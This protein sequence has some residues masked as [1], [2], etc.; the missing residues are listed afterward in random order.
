MNS[1]EGILSLKNCDIGY[2]L[3]KHQSVLLENISLNLNSSNLIALIGLNGSGK[4]SLLK[5][6]VNLL[7]GLKGQID[8]LG[9]NILDYSNQELAKI[10]GF[11]S[12]NWQPE[13]NMTVAELVRLGR[14]PYT[15]IFGQ[16]NEKDLRH[17]E[18]SILKLGLDELRNRPLSQISD[19]ER[20]RAML[21][22]VFAQQT[23]IIVLDEPTAF[24][25]IQHKY[26]IINSLKILCKDGITVI[27]STHDINLASFFVD[28]FWLIQ[29]EKIMNGA[30]EDLFLNGSIAKL[31]SSGDVEFDLAEGNFLPRI[32]NKKSIGLVFESTLNVEA[33]WT[34]KALVRKGFSISEDSQRG[35]SIEI[36]QKNHTLVWEIK[37][38]NSV[39][40]CHSIL[41]LINK[42]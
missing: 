26:E 24:L 36:V 22:R 39:I 23:K 31:F 38:D 1:S 29:G 10:I 28:E 4:S 5:T 35:D 41:E 8:I 17:V 13:E 7:P 40:E 19:G 9:K 33:N 12:A 25:D 15:N 34:K 18:E 6:I 37:R 27:F 42:L 21:A 32:H 2:Q 30:P 14:Y 20:Q 16:L 3:G 11:V